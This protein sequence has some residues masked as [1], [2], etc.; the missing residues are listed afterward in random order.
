M[1]E[2]IS[3]S[4]FLKSFTEASAI[5][6]RYYF[7][8]QR[9]LWIQSLET[10]NKT[11]IIFPEMNTLGVSRDV[12]KVNPDAFLS[13]DSEIYFDLHVTYQLIGRISRF[14]LGRRNQITGSG[15]WKRWEMLRCSVYTAK[16]KTV[17]DFVPLKKPKIIGNIL[18]IFGGIIISV[19]AFC[20]KN[21]GVCIWSCFN[22]THAWRKLVL[23]FKKYNS[24]EAY[25][26]CAVAAK[27]AKTQ[28]RKAYT[29]IGT[30]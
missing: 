22:F 20:M 18:V 29:N 11:A 23:F 24:W 12:N 1:L 14:I 27:K 7:N 21:F 6:K 30:T 17:Q 4:W 19:V 10:C 16:I 13:I 25:K 15:I 28:K 26:R 3:D 2:A 5:I 8:D 9:N